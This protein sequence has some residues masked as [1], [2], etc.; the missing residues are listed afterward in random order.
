[1]MIPYWTPDRNIKTFYAVSLVNFAR[2][3]TMYKHCLFHMLII[4]LI[5]FIIK[6]IDQYSII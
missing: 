2:I 4:W 1:M 6:R 5:L 3:Q